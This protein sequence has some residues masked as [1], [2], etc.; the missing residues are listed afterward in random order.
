LQLRTAT[1]GTVVVVVVA[2]SHG[3]ASFAAID[4]PSTSLAVVL[5]VALVLSGARDETLGALLVAVVSVGTA[6]SAR[7]CT[8]RLTCGGGASV[9][10]PETDNKAATW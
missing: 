2:L 4:E 9:S 5:V 3:H 1:D 6:A 7:L 10:W 8:D